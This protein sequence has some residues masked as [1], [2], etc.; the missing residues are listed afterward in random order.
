MRVTYHKPAARGVSQ[1]M[2]VGDDE[3]TAGP[4]W[5]KAVQYAVIG[6]LGWMMW[7]S[8]STLDERAASLERERSA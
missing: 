8:L 4:A 7:R 2:Y 5:P 3:A 6:L 1:L